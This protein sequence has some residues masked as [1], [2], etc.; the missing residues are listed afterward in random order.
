MLVIFSGCSGVGKNTIIN[1]LISENDSYG[2]MPTYTT[3]DR[4]PGEEDGVPYYFLTDEQFEEKIAEGEFY[5]YER[6][7]NH[8]YGTSRKLLAD[9]VASGKTLMKDIDVN[10]AINLSNILKDDVKIVPLFLYVESADILVER[11]TGRGEKDIELRLKR[12]EHEMS[13]I[14]MYS[15]IINN[16]SLENTKILADELIK[17]EK[18]NGKL[19]SA[20]SK[21]NIS[22]EKINETVALYEKG[23]YPEPIKVSV[24]DG[25]FV[26]TEG[27]ERYIASLRCGKTIAKDLVLASE[28]T[29]T[30]EIDDSSSEGKMKKK[31]YKSNKD[32][33]IDGVCAGIGEYFDIDPTLVRLGCVALAIFGGSGVLAYIIAAIV[34]PRRPENE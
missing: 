23:E 26:I 6:V 3:R 27:V 5:E 14:R 11:L 32:K 33:M 12:Y 31:L 24:C 4:R 7:H 1:K 19:L 9:S 8:Y 18:R 15:Y 30:Y 2:I 13:K 28:I 21:E 29:V 22:E 25:K 20:V 10:G 34:I 16:S 17:F